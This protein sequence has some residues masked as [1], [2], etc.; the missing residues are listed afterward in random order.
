VLKRDK[1][2]QGR[3]KRSGASMFRYGGHILQGV[4]MLRDFS[5]S[6]G[7]FNLLYTPDAPDGISFRK[8]TDYV[9]LMQSPDMRRYYYLRASY[10]GQPSVGSLLDDIERNIPPKRVNIEN[11]EHQNIDR[12]SD[13]HELY[14]VLIN[15]LIADVD[16][17]TESMTERW[18]AGIYSIVR[19]MGSV[20][21]MPFPAASLAWTT[22]HMSIDIQRG[23]L[24]YHD[25][26]R[27]T[28]SWF[29]GTT[30]FGSLLGAAGIK[31]VLTRDQALVVQIGSWAVRKLASR[32]A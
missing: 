2:L 29:F 13:I 8:L 5:T 11:P 28:A 9:A 27:A 15:R 6:D 19:M 1:S 31:T 23:V 7:D 26:D 18:A 25:G 10:K 24:A 32:I 3:V 21:L 22:L 30:V 17:Q 16:A 12:V 20:L 14:D 4:Y